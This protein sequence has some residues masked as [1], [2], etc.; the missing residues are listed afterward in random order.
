MHISA[1]VPIAALV[2]SCFAVGQSKDA[3]GSQVK[4]E[5]TDRVTSTSVQLRKGNGVK[6]TYDCKCRSSSGGTCEY[7]QGPNVMTCFGGG[8]H[9][10]ND[11]AFTTSSPALRPSIAPFKK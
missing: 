5:P 2:F 11:C 7:G 9:P 1:F 3:K 6:G 4:I 10:C 8:E